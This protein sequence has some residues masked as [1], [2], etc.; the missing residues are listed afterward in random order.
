MTSLALALAFNN[1]SQA[2]ARLLVYL[3]TACVLLAALTYPTVHFLCRDFR[4]RRRAEADEEEH[5]LEVTR[6]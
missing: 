2:G 5:E 6:L 3:Q 4:R 1:G